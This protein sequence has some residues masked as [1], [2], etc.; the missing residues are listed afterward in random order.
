MNKETKCPYCNKICK[1]PGELLT[2]I[3]LKH[4][5]NNEVA[6]EEVDQY[7]NPVKAFVDK[8]TGRNR[9]NPDEATEM[10]NIYANITGKPA[11]SITCPGCIKHMWK[12]LNANI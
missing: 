8:M 10:A 4:P 6:I 12:V 9:M 3:R 2:H 7:I 1:T 5:N 11:Q